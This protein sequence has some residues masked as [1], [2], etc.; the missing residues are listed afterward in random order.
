M[1]PDQRS[2]AEQY[3]PC[4]F[5]CHTCQFIGYIT[6]Y[7]VVWFCSVSEDKRVEDAAF[8]PSHTR[9]CFSKDFTVSASIFAGRF[10]DYDCQPLL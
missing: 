2:D 3:L 10:Y 7:D 9:V 8:L 5:S 6:D 1:R 4:G